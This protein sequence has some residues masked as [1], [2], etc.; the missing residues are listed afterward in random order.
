MII[1]APVPS[2]LPLAPGARVRALGGRAIGGAT[3]Y[4]LR[5]AMLMA[6]PAGTM[7]PGAGIWLSTLPAGMVRK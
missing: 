3:G 7:V 6:V 5:T 4:Y 2:L 1:G